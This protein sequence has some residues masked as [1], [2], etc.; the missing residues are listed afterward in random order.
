MRL[1]SEV[2]LIVGFLGFVAILSALFFGWRWLEARLFSS[3]PDYTVTHVAIETQ[4]AITPEHI[5][6]LTGIHEGI[7]IFSFSASKKREELL[8]NRPNLA[9]VRIQKILPDTVRITALDRLP[10]LRIEGTHFATDSLGTVMAID[11]RQR[12]RWT[13]LPRLSE[14]N[15][16]VNVVPGQTLTD[17][18]AIALAIIN[19]YN[20]MSGIGFRIDAIDVSGRV[21]VTLEVV[22]RNIYREVRLVWEEMTSQAAMQN[23]LWMASEAL[24]KPEAATLIRFDVLLETQTVYGI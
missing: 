14:G 15:R 21:Y 5:K 8:R 4:L 22:D 1:R 12:L 20:S 6:A 2:V 17:R 3:N 19:V 9:D 24:A 18:H 23:A 16:P 13:S 7:N 11:E 10:V